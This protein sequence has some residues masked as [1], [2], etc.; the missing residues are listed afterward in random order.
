MLAGT[1][2]S[3]GTLSVIE[4]N[5]G[6]F[7]EQDRH[8]TQGLRIDYVTAPLE[9]SGLPNASFDAIGLVLPMYRDDP[10]ARRELEVEALGQ[11][12]FTPDDTRKK[13]PDPKDRPYA[14]WLYT[15]L[16]WLQENDGRSLNGLEA[17]LG[18]VGKAALGREAQNAFHSIT[19]FP[20]AKG[21]S[22]QLDNRFAAQ[23]S[24]DHKRRLALGLRGRYDFDLVPEAGL[25]MGTAL[26]Y[27]DAGV[28]LR[29][30]DAL[31]CDYGAEHIRPAPSG[32]AFVEPPAVAVG[33]LRFY[34]YAG[35]Q[36][37]YMLYN[38][39]IDAADEVQPTN[40]E[41]TDWVTDIVCGLRLFLPWGLRGDVAV[42]ERSR[43]FHG[44]EEHD[45][46]GS[47]SMSAT[48]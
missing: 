41:R 43:E 13:H 24:Y 48:F 12:L 33:D 10:S 34:V 36:Q 21:W 31:G 17:Q 27:L 23:F 8:Y 14:A 4:E 1:A 6:M 7:S 46:V 26:R 45:R 15:G 44:Q 35:V 19:W 20:R 5:D 18:V 40:L 47:A 38:V 29:F 37:R 32:T 11:S 2:A 39:F 42:I 16:A 30:G 9:R 3:A 25:S 28:L 22:H